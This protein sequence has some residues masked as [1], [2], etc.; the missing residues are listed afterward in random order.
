MPSSNLNWYLQQ[1]GNGKKCSP[2]EE[3]NQCEELYNLKVN[4]Y[5]TI[6]TADPH[7]IDDNF[8]EFRALE[9]GENDTKDPE[10]RWKLV[11]PMALQYLQQLHYS[12][13]GATAADFE[14]ISAQAEHISKLYKQWH[15]T[16]DQFIRRHA[17]L[18][19]S[20]AKHYHGIPLEE[21]IQVA[22]M[23]LSRALDSYDH[24][25]GV[26]FSSYAGDWVV[27]SVERAIADHRSNIR[28]P[29]RVYQ[30]L[31][32]VRYATQQLLTKKGEAPLEQIAVSTELPAAQIEELLRMSEPRSLDKPLSENSTKHDFVEDPSADPFREVYTRNLREVFDQA[33]ATLS[34]RQQE[35]IRRR[36]GLNEQQS[37]E[38]LSV[39]GTSLRLTRE[40]IRQIETVAL[41]NLKKDPRLQRLKFDLKG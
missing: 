8:E 18:A 25:R 34:P 35:I 40:R 12:T 15:K 2:E 28:K 11:S 38:S 13:L 10:N 39:I 23:G 30:A 4:L 29:I 3:Y 14:S 9:R 7:F 1:G 33:I 17:G 6:N 26:R 19:V 22:L 36:F 41:K 27:Q 20:I 16:K 21:S 5:Q 32:K 24:N 37:E 31:N